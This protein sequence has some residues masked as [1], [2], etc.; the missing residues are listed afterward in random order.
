MRGFLGRSG[1]AIVLMLAGASKKLM[2]AM[3]AMAS[4]GLAFAQQPQD[5]PKD[6]KPNAAATP[7]SG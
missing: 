2:V 5:A 6:V 1:A 4:L 3:M 7:T